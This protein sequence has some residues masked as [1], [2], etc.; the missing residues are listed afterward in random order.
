[1]PNKVTLKQERFLLS[2]GTPL[3]SVQRANFL[4]ELHSGAVKIIK[5][6]NAKKSTK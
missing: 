5:K 6:I 3:T 4:R 1:M 2:K